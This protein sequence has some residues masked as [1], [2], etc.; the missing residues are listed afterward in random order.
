MKGP[1][2]DKSPYGEIGVKGSPLAYCIDPG[3]GSASDHV[4]R[5]WPMPA[6]LKLIHERGG[7]IVPLYAR[8]EVSDADLEALAQPDPERKTLPIPIASAKRIAKVYG[9]DQVVIYGRNVRDGHPD[10]ITTYGATKELC[11]IA[12]RISKT[13]QRWMGWIDSDGTPIPAGEG[14]NAKETSHAE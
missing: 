9:Y 2:P 12:G 11:A 8:P 10:H 5:F 6:E 4:T 3:A 1:F 7:E 13:F 14:P